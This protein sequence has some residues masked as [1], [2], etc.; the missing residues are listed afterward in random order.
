[1]L[2]ILTTESFNVNPKNLQPWIFFSGKLTI[3]CYMLTIILGLVLVWKYDRNTE[4]KD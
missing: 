2:A 4:N 3:V 1:M